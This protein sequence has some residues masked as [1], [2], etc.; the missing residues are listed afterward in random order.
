MVVDMTPVREI[1]VRCGRV[2]DQTDDSDSS[3]DEIHILTDAFIHT[4]NRGASYHRKRC[5]RRGSASRY[6]F[7]GR[8]CVVCH[9]EFALMPCRKPLNYDLLLM[10]KKAVVPPII[11]VCMHELAGVTNGFELRSANCQALL[12]HIFCATR[13][14][15]L[16]QPPFQSAYL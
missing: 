1:Q 9:M 14:A 4:T 15:L 5:T 7:L 8:R 3:M 16:C 10:L 6:C 11:L 12:L 2:F 13:L